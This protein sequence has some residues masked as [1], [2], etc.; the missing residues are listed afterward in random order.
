MKT[1]ANAE[2]EWEDCVEFSMVQWPKLKIQNDEMEPAFTYT[3]NGKMSG[4]N[5]TRVNIF[6]YRN[7]LY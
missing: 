2:N 5:D 4:P 3:K 1:L 7:A 6:Q